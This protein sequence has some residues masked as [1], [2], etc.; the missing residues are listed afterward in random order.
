MR[1]KRK[2][3]NYITIINREDNSNIKDIMNIYNNNW[4]DVNMKKIFNY[5]YKILKK[6][7]YKPN[8]YND[9]EILEFKWTN[10]I[11]KYPILFYYYDNIEYNTFVDNYNKNLIKNTIKKKDINKYIED[12]DQIILNILVDIHNMPFISLDILLYIE[13]NIDQCKLYKFDHLE[14]Y[15]FYK[16]NIIEEIVINI[17]IITKLFYTIN[18]KSI[19]KLIYFDTPFKKKI[20]KTDTFLSCQ[21]I[22]SG[23]Y[24]SGHNIIIWRREEIY[25]VLM[26]ELI[27][28]LDIDI[29]NDVK[30]YKFFKYNIGIYN[31]NILINESITEIQAQLYHTMYC[32]IITNKLDLNESYIIFK[33]LYYYENCFN[34]YQMNKI[35]KFYNIQ[36][37]NIDIIKEKFN[38]TT[39]CFSYY[40]LKAIFNLNISKIIILFDYLSFITNN[41]NKCNYLQCDKLYNIINQLIDNIPVQLINNALQTDLYNDTSL[42]MILTT[43]KYN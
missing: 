14:L 39:N 20:N 5:I 28:Y 8:Y 6:I 21:N 27:H 32:S 9:V 16:S 13:N 34:W 1:L 25:K 37:Y 42:K 30:I 26:H 24:H 2:T 22:N 10:I 18:P 36:E 12:I 40:I 33:K 35:M 38:Q 31:H 11:H 19:I 23:M 41:N 7:I 4:N 17:Y 15:Y 3:Y 43:L 29:K